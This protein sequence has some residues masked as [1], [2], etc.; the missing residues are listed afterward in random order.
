MKQV[1]RFVKKLKETNLLD[2]TVVVFGSGMSDGS[3][4]VTNVCLSSL[5]WWL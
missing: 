4:T 5:P 3:P 1:T 2:D